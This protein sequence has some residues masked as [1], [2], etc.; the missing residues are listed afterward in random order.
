[1]WIN[2]MYDKNACMLGWR[3]KWLETWSW[4]DYKDKKNE[5]C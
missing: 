2:D 4:Q 3:W 1:M 5:L